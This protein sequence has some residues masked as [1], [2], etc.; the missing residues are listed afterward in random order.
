MLGRIRPRTPATDHGKGGVLK[1][2]IGA[3][4]ET[5]CT[6]VGP[7]IA[8]SFRDINPPMLWPIM[9][10]FPPALKSKRDSMKALASVT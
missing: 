6:E 7:R 9:D 3:T 5:E 10:I 1:H 2:S 4:V 8:D